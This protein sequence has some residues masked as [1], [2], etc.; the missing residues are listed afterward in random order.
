[1][2]LLNKVATVN[3]ADITTAK[4]WDAGMTYEPKGGKRVLFP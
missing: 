3:F 4:S 2:E 1:M